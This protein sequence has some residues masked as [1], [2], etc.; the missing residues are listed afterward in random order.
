VGS[1]FWFGVGATVLGVILVPLAW[2]F[3]R[4]F[5]KRKLESWPGEGQPIPY[6][7]ETVV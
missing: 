1:I 7:D 3:K 5:F 4:D 6:Q 2:A